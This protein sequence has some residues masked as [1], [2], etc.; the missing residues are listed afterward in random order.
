MNH[1]A[2]LVL[3]WFRPI[4]G[5]ASL[6]IRIVLGRR[7]LRASDL[8]TIKKNLR[9]HASTWACCWLPQRRQP[10]C[11]LHGAGRRVA[12]SLF[13]RRVALAPPV[14][15]APQRSIMPRIRLR[16]HWRSQCHPS[17]RRR[18]TISYR[19]GSGGE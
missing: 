11:C 4:A 12:L 6:P 14:F 10:C 16:K 17:G 13:R 19:N 3:P 8:A 15:R 2:R 7:P 1:Y 5:A 9:G 18:R